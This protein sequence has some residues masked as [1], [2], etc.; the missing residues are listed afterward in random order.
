MRRGEVERGYGYYAYRVCMYYCYFILAGEQFTDS[1]AVCVCG[2]CPDGDSGHSTAPQ[3]GRLR[4]DDSMEVDLSLSLKGLVFSFCT[5][6]WF[7]KSSIINND[8]GL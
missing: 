1:A 7:L 8:S 5:H 6:S 3:P 4:A 2:V